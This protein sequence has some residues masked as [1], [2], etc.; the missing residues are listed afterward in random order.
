MDLSGL[1]FEVA[2]SQNGPATS[3]NKVDIVFVIDNSGS[4]GD[5]IEGVK[6]HITI[7]VNS[8]EQNAS[9][10]VDYRIGFVMHGNDKILVKRFTDSAAEFQQAII[11]TKQ[12]KTG[13][14][15][16]GL[17][18]IDIAADFPWDEKRHKFI[19][20]FTDESTEGGHDPQFQLSKFDLL[21]SKLETLR[22]KIYYLGVD[23]EDYRRFKEV[24][25]TYY[26]P[27][28][29]FDHV[30]FS[31]LLN[32]IGKSVSQASGVSLQGGQNKVEKDLYD[33]SSTV[34]IVHL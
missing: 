18:A 12:Y 2:G 30:D 5:V 9:N 17:P 28:D 1:D 27:N 33:A 3:K 8:L 16:F 25:G 10:K 15:E 14:N 29:T 13:W 11:E 4:M 31:E 20:I 6:N 24:P 26:E 34:E 19:I 22:T 23:A 32:K 21:L 7:F